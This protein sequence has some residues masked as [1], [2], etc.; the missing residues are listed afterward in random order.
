MPE[1]PGEPLPMD[2][3]FRLLR[4]ERRTAIVDVGANPIDGDPPYKRMLARG[5]CTVV[6]F[7]PQRKALECLQRQGGPLERYLPY[8]VGDGREHTFH[9]CAEPGMSGLL[10]PDPRSLALF[11]LFE[12]FGQVR[13]TERIT[14]RSLD[15]VEEITH[16]DFLK[17]DVQGSELSIFQ[18]GRAAL[19]NAVAIQTE[20]S[21]TPLYEGQPTFADVD[22]ELRAQGF[23]LHMFVDTKRWILSPMVINNNPRQALNQVLEADVVYVRDYRSPDRFTAEQWKHLGLIA[24]HAYGSFDLAYRCILILGKELPDAGP[25]YLDLLRNL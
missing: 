22:A 3:L 8:A 10:R 12:E 17:I 20:M 25:A 13:S 15:S 14:T 18:N 4:P 21:F 5:I 16:L 9:H 6:G 23:I 2:P 19:S 1:H 7:E 11:P 24:H